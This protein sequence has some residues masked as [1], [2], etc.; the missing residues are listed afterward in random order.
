MNSDNVLASTMYRGTIADMVVTRI[1]ILVD[2]LAGY[3]QCE[4][5]ETRMW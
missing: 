3:V 1:V 5:V 4:D 2:V